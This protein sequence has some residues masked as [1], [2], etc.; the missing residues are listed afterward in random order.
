[1]NEPG[2]LCAFDIYLSDLT[3]YDEPQPILR[4]PLQPQIHVDDQEEENLARMKTDIKA[5][6]NVNSKFHVS[7]LS[8][9]PSL[10]PLLWTLSITYLTTPIPPDFPQSP[11]R[12][13]PESRHRYSKYH[14]DKIYNPIPSIIRPLPP[15]ALPPPNRPTSFTA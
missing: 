13:D 6:R 14:Q 5:H 15:S 10:N 2:G 4:C 11:G 9:Q 12:P 1:M 3:S 8:L 7:A